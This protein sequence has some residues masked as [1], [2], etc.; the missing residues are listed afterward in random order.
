REALP[1]VARRPAEGRGPIGGPQRTGSGAA[2]ARATPS[3]S[4]SVRGPSMCPA[5][6]PPRPV[7]A[8]LRVLGYPPSGAQT[9]SVRGGCWWRRPSS[10]APGH[11]ATP[12]SGVRPLRVPSCLRPARAGGS[13]GMAG[14]LVL[15]IDVGGTKLAA[16]VVGRD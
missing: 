14:E 5:A 15:A 6:P 3:R 13:G 7:D 9:S 8:D 1:G 11:R 4:G 10:S 2:Y 12:P 16:A